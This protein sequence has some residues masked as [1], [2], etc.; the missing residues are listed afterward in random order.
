MRPGPPAGV[1]VRTAGGRQ[2]RAGSGVSAKGC[3]G[4]RAQVRRYLGAGAGLLTGA[5]WGLG[6]CL[7]NSLSEV[8]ISPEPN[9]YGLK[10]AQVNPSN[11]SVW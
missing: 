4:H 9:P 5:A 2:Y 3:P 8:N 11:G 6:N 10:R 1:A 7:V